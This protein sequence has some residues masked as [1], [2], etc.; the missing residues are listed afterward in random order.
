[1]GLKANTKAVEHAKVGRHQIEG[2]K[3]LYLN[4]GEHSARWLFRYHRPDGRPNETGIGSCRDVTLKQ[5]IERAHRLRQHVLQGGDPVVEKRERHHRAKVDGLTVRTVLDRYASDLSLRPS[6]RT[7]VAMIERHAGA[8]LDLP[9]ASVTVALVK[10]AID[11]VQQTT[12]KMAV[13]VR[14]GLNALWSYA[15]ASELTDRN[16]CDPM[17]WRHLATRPRTIPHRMLPPREVPA[18]F[19]RLTARDGSVSAALA[20]LILVAA[21][22]TEVLGLR[23]QEVDLDQ[24]MVT[25]A[26]SRMKSGREHRYPISDPASAILMTMR[27]RHGADGYVFKADHGGQLSS[28]CLHCLLQR[29]LF[30]PFSVHG[31]RAAFSSWAHETTDHPHE[32]IELAL[33]HSE[34]RGNAVARA[35]N[36]AD[37]V[38][39]RRALMADWGAF[40][41][42]GR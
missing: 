41:I 4:V 37:M 24:R 25:I 40:V 3:G 30:V 26:G 13:R 17:V 39:R 19:A 23:W 16:P 5:A 27:D 32:L 9:I 29:Q 38:E 14:A 8:L 1:M 28:R 35:Y 18:L 12:P 15:I 34:G 11:P 21:R 10:D 42:G 31:F 33:A 36:R 6:T 22:T 20:Y 7:V 2:T